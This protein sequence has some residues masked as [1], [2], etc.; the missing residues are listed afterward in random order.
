MMCRIW[1][2]YARSELITKVCPSG[3]LKSINNLH[4]VRQ[5]CKPLFL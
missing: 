5:A 3:V 2:G 4:L 1:L